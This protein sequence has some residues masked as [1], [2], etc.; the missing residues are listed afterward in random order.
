MNFKGSLESLLKRF[1]KKK[2]KCR[3]NSMSLKVRVARGCGALWKDI[4]V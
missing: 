2:I 4:D 1:L 3:P